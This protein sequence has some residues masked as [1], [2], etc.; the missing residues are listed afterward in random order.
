MVA[1][2]GFV[3]ALIVGSGPQRHHRR[4]SIRTVHERL[5]AAA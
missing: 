4:P 2:D 3:M 1:S 5:L